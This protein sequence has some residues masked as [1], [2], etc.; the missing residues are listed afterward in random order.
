MGI[1]TVS[2]SPR[3]KGWNTFHSFVPDWMINMNSSLYTWNNGD[4]YLHYTKDLAS[5]NIYNR[6][7]GVSYPSTIT[8][9]F[10]KNST[11]AK[12]FKTICLE[13][14][15][16]WK[17]ELTTDL[18]TG[19]IEQDYFIEK[20][21]DFYGYIR[22]PEG[23]LDVEML[24]TQGIGELTSI[25]SLT[26]TFNFDFDTVGEGDA[27]YIVGTPAFQFA[28]EFT[29]IGNVTTYTSNTITVDAITNLP[30]STD[31][32]VTAKSSV[33]ESY[34]PRGYYM[35]VKL[36]DT[37]GFKAKSAELFSISSEV[38]KSSP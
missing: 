38:F 2:F 12:V 25:A 16:A 19:I 20:E 36:T 1:E 23:D 5:N 9:V 37:P 34:A 21:G 18:S 4:L 15:R 22:R 26:L 8:T 7:Y 13:S 6:Y 24:S 29:F 14:N 17:A 35:E 33:A 31:F 10:N 32:I 28:P 3:A 30:V 11:D 27:L